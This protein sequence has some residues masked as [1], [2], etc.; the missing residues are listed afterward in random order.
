MS[1]F[2]LKTGCDIIATHSRRKAGGRADKRMG[3]WVGAVETRRSWVARSSRDE[4]S[5]PSD[6]D[7]RS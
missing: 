2:V 1:G 6:A 5:S 3:S 4:A 7:G